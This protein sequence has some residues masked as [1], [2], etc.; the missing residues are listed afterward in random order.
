V[1]PSAADPRQEAWYQAAL[2]GDSLWG[3]PLK[4]GV[5][6][7]LVPL[8]APIRTPLGETCG[9]LS[10]MVAL[11]GVLEELVASHPVNEGADRIYLLDP[12]GRVLA[13]TPAGAGSRSK[14]PELLSPF[15]E[16]KLVTAA[17]A[18]GIRF[19]ESYEFGTRSFLG[20]DNV[21]PFDWILVA[22]APEE[23]LFAR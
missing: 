8:T 2:K 9:A 20:F 13:S 5:P 21:H 16:P 18:D 15:A 7:T 17:H 22:E 1:A 6:G 10:L 12:A 23:R 19:L 14:A 11:D 4:N 3:E